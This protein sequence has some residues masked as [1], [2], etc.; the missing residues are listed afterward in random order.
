MSNIRENIKDFVKN[1]VL[2]T[3]KTEEERTV[4]TELADTFLKLGKDVMTMTPEEIAEK[5]TPL[6]QRGSV[7]LE[8]MLDDTQNKT[9]DATYPVSAHNVENWYTFLANKMVIQ[10]IEDK[11]VVINAVSLR[12]KLDDAL[13]SEGKTKDWQLIKV[14]EN[15]NAKAKEQ[16]NSVIHYSSF[17]IPRWDKEIMENTKEI[18]RFV[19]MK[20]LSRLTFDGFDGYEEEEDAEVPTSEK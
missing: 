14:L 10:F 3:L 15:M 16:D 13:S 4:F 2:P 19:D 7:S 9:Q 5:C 11:M 18:K 6:I 17:M 12:K 8:D 20:V 1:K